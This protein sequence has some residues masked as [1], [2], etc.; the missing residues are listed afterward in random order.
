MTTSDYSGVPASLDFET[1]D[2][3]QS[4]VITAV[5]DD[6]DETDET[7]TLGFGTLLEGLTG[8]TNTQAVV[9]ISD[10]IHVS[11]GAASYQ[12]HEGRAGAVVAVEL[13]GPAPEETVIPLTATGMNGAT[14]A[15]WTGVPGNLTFAPGDTRNTFTVMAY[16]DDVEDG[17]ERRRARLRHA[18][19][20]SGPGDP[21]HGH[22][23]ADEHGDADLRDRRMVRQR[24]VRR[25]WVGRLE[26]AGPGAG[27][28]HHPGTLPALFQ[29][30]RQPVHLPGQGVPGME[31]VHLPRHP[32]GRQ[33]RGPR[34]VSRS[35]RRSQYAS[36]RWWETT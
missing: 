5:Q 13:D 18:P 10:S 17:G 1:G 26:P 21:V 22:G 30:Q 8:G 24:G 35:T 14:S 29:P 34:A 12:A 20:R 2:T 15:D 36:W 3:G 23:G 16:D 25:L 4:F 33:P 9:T 27:L 31:P 6:D 11:F 32:S 7:L 28:P 19:G